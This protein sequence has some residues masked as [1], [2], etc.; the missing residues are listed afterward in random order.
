MVRVHATSLDL[1][2][3]PWNLEP[4]DPDAL[5]A[6]AATIIRNLT[7]TAVYATNA[8]GTP[9]DPGIAAALRDATCAQAVWFDDTGDTGSGAASVY[10]TVSLGSARLSVGGA[11]SPANVGVNQSRISPEAVQILAN[12]GLVT[13]QVQSW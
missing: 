8:D 9:T 6:R 1:A 4:A 13:G 11:G 3:E 2:G 12:A 5:L 10:S 7:L